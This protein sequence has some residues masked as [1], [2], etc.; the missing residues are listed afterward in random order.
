MESAI[1]MKLVTIL[2]AEHSLKKIVRSIVGVPQM[3]LSF[4]VEHKYYL[5]AYR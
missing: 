2:F 1:E 5:V 4:A 3:E